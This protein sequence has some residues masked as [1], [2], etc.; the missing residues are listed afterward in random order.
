MKCPDCAG[1]L[2]DV[3]LT[4]I[5]KS[6]RCF[7]C[8]GVW[9]I[10]KTVNGLP[11][12]DQS[13]QWQRIEVDPERLKT[14][15]NR[16][17]NDQTEL[18]YYKGGLIPAEFKVRQCPVCHWWWWP[19]DSL[20]NF[21]PL[22]EARKKE[23]AKVRQLMP[24]MMAALVPLLS[25]VLLITGGVVGVR[26]LGQQQ[27]VK[28]AAAQRLSEVAGIKFENGDATVTFVYAGEVKTAQVFL[29]DESKWV[30]VTVEKMEQNR[31]QISFGKTLAGGEE[32]R[33]R[34]NGEEAVVPFRSIKP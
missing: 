16:C 1:L 20:F 2:M 9:A 24:M 7:N 29:T 17:P 18:E 15:D 14:G 6:Y 33:I 34:V 25:L 23:K 31:Y 19:T 8:G 3:T 10:A 27:Q 12:E 4:G 11:A 32:V 5:D 13:G 21:K 28:V 30:P 22:Q 26:L